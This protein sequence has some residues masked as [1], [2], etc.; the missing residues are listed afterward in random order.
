MTMRDLPIGNDDFKSIRDNGGYYVD[1]TALIAEIVSRRSTGAFL[2]TRPR[3]FGKSLNLSMID[4]FFNLQYGGCRWFE[5]LEV[6]SDRA[7]LDMM[8]RFPVVMVSLK[9]LETDTYEDFINDFREITHELCRRF[10]YLFES[11]NEM[12]GKLSE[13][14]SRSSTEALMK[15]SIKDLTEALESYHGRKTIVLIDEYDS[16]INSSYGKASHKKIVTIQY[17]GMTTTFRGVRL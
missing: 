3:R 12:S 10:G 7:S 15:R 8:N 5:G 2:F 14:K 9:G 11:R 4:A 16:A 13:L 1:K 6:M 17:P